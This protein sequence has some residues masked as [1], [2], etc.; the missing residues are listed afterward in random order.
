MAASDRPP[1]DSPSGGGSVAEGAD[2]LFSLAFRNLP[3]A[4]AI[5]RA[6]DGRILEVNQAFLELTGYPRTALQGATTVSIGLWPRPRDRARMLETLQAQGELRD[7]SVRLRRADGT[8][9]NVLLGAR[10]LQLGS[11]AC[12]ITVARDITDTLEQQRERQTLARLLALHPQAVQVLNAQGRHLTGNAAFREL[13]GED[14]PPTWSL[15]EDPNLQ[16]LGLLE[17]VAPLAQ[18]RA[19]TLTIPD[20]DVHAVDPQRPSNPRFLRTLAFP[21][22]TAEDEVSSILLLHEDLTDWHRAET[23]LRRSEARA[24]HLFLTMAQGIL[25]V[26]AEGRI[27]SANPAAEG[28]LGIA[29][30]AMKGHDFETLGWTWLHADGSPLP[31]ERTPPTVALREGRSL[32]GHVLGLLLHDGRCRW[33]SIGAH[34]LWERDSQ[35]PSG[36]FCTFTDITD[37]KRTQDELRTTSQ[38]LQAVLQGSAA[39]IFQLAPDGTFLL[40]EG[41]ALANLGLKPGEVIGLNALELYRDYPETVALLRSAL[42]GTEQRATL[43]VAG[44]WFDTWVTPLFEGDRVTSVVGVATDITDRMQAETTL[45]EVE[46]RFRALVNHTTDNLFWVHRRPNGAFHIDGVNPA[47]WKTYGLTGDTLSGHDLE[48]VLPPEEAR[49]ISEHYRRCLDGGVPITYQETADLPTGRRTFQTLLVPI[50][51]SDGTLQ[52]LVGTSRDITELIRREESLREAQKLESLGLLAGGIAHDF[53]NLLAAI[54]GNLNLAQAQVPEGAPLKTYLERAE[55]TVLRASELTKQLLAYSGKAPFEVKPQDLNALVR[56]WTHLLS[57]TVSKQIRLDL[58]LTEPLPPIQG[59]TAQLQQ[60]ILNLVTNAGEAIGDREGRIRIH[61]RCQIL[62]DEDLQGTIPSCPLQ[63]GPHVVLEV[64]DDGSGMP[65]EVQERMFDPFYSTK[66]S[67]RGLGLS[68]L[69]GILR[70]H[71]GGLKLRSQPGKG[72]TF[73]LFFPTT[74]APCPCPCPSPQP[75]QVPQTYAGSVLVAEDEPLVREFTCGA[76]E[77]MGFQ[78]V[79]T[80][81]GEEA[82]EAFKKDPFRFRLALLDYTMPRRNGRETLLALQAL[83]PDFPVVL[84]SGYSARECLGPLQDAPGAV[85]F[86]PKPYHLS[87]LRR[88]LS[89]LLGQGPAQF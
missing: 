24:R 69:L 21:W 54:L 86:L 71:H 44:R 12:L 72:T 57:V 11:E 1:L 2:A 82:L 32:V 76:L 33:V 14:F 85:R 60:V 10:A 9:R 68:A 25:E 53:N 40:S 47:Q 6:E 50:P 81:D 16:R 73:T 27:L 23:A 37:L 56:E 29:L 66:G 52:H 77:L 75:S 35:T 17:Q 22:I 41:R 74:E 42:E 59:D 58:D 39:V 3:D 62:R 46:D 20:Y 63:P 88:V 30:E 84:C 28:I 18:G 83:R 43:A 31:P 13:F 8:L 55:R 70:S 4:A 87:D 15:F 51:A 61:T 49:R 64:S 79:A 19:V 5:T 67:G 7:F 38:R 48:E 26:D 78:T 45:R 89:D 36:A 34:P 65:I 80:S